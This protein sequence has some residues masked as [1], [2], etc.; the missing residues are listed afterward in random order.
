MVGSAFPGIIR[1]GIV[2]DSP[3]LVQ[4]KGTNVAESL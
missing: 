1:N 4:F 3:N 2:E